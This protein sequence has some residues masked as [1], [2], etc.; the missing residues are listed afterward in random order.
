MQIGFSFEPDC[1]CDDPVCIGFSFKCPCCSKEV[2]IHPRGLA[3]LYYID[4]LYSWSVCAGKIVRC[5][6]CKVKLK[7]ITGS[8]YLGKAEFEIVK[9]EGINL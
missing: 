8:D 4:M 2:E 1:G 6:H 5:P 3:Q 9:K 7:A